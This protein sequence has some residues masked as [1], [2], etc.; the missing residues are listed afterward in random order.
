MVPLTLRP[1][2]DDAY[3]LSEM[4]LIA[5]I[6]LDATL[7]DFD[8]FLMLFV[9]LISDIYFTIAFLSSLN[10]TRNSDNALTE[11]KAENVLD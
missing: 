5:S 7:S 9:P 6:P 2:V 3:K 1:T 11:I 10:S 8:T 4:L